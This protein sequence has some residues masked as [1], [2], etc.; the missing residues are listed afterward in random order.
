M[1]RF[2]VSITLL[3]LP[4]FAYA[5]SWDIIIEKPTQCKSW[6]EISWLFQAKIN[7]TQE[8]QLSNSES[9]DFSWSIVYTLKKD[10]DIIESINDREKYLHY[11]TMAW[12]YVLEANIADS[13]NQ[14]E[15]IIEKKIKIYKNIL[16][17][18]WTELSWLKTWIWDILEKNNI[19]L[20]SYSNKTILSQSK[21]SQI[22][23]DSI[24]QSDYFI[25]WSTDILWFFSDIVKLQKLKQ[26]DFTKKKI[27]IISNFSKSFLS[28]VLAS[29]L[30]QIGATKVFLI[31]ENQLYWIIARI[32]TWENENLNVWQELSYEKWKTV[33]SLSGFIEFLAYAG[34]S[35]QLLALLLSITFIVL[36][37]N[38]M[39][40]VIG[41]NV[42]WI[43][44]PV[45]LAV[46]I[47][48]VGFSSA[49]IFMIIGFISII[50]VNLFSKKVHLLLHAKRSLLI[51]I[52]IMLFLFF[53]WIDNFFE[54]SYIN[55]AIFDNSLI[56][57]PFFFTIIVA[58]KIFQEDI[59]LISKSWI[60][61]ILQYIIITYIIY[62]L[63]EFKTLQY[64]LISYPDI[65]IL[66]VFLNILVGRYIW[67][68][69][70]EYLRF[71]PL[72]KKLNE[73]EE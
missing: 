70:F 23:W 44:Y 52:Y 26:I 5:E 46:T 2:I 56:I 63:F 7:S 18:I 36:I 67:L 41:F 49:A 22:I 57:F 35:Y 27:Y 72:L 37:L 53:L 58:D 42:F 4:F 69:A 64:F 9:K 65:I 11:F 33:Y 38:F 25:A 48:S 55:Y 17:Y 40:Q 10:N 3:F 21:E 32:S 60:I 29:S 28:K 8:Y 1:Y 45:L 39:K 51:S 61:E 68:Q 62:S 24:D 34:F 6:Y 50:S 12:E 13:V 47:A 15:I 20:N 59:Y 19:L 66:V 16:L 54:L 31:T 73:E 14:C 43:Y 71:S 30:S